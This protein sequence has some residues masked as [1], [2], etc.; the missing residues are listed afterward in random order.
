[1]ENLRIEARCACRTVQHAGNEV[2]RIFYPVVGGST[3]AAAHTAA[4]IEA[5]VAYAETT[6]AEAA[7]E[8]LHSAAS[9]GRLFDFACHT[10]QITAKAEKK[11]RHTTVTLAAEHT[12]GNTP[13]PPRTL[14]MH[15]DQ[16][17][18]L[19]CKRPPQGRLEKFYSFL[20]RTRGKYVKI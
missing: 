8:A 6:V 20:L 14:T 12:A 19:Q 3:A 4:L 13:S 10:Y 15:W 1:M 2:L 7:A 18:A 17:E 16:G 9:E 5:L 11:A